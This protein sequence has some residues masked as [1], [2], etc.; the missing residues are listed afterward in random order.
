MTDKIVIGLTGNI[1]TGKSIV[2]RMLQELG[3]T[4]IDADKLVHLLMRQATP[5]YQAIVKEFGP[6]V[7][8]KNG[9]ISRAR[10][11]TIVFSDPTRLARLEAI[12]HPPVRKVILRRIEESPTPVVAIEAIKLFESG[13]SEYCQSNWVIVAKPELQLKRLVERRRMSPELA[14]QRIR[15]QGAQH[16][17]AAKADIVIDNSG[18]LVKTWSIVKQHYLKLTASL[19]A[20][21]EPVAETEASVAPATTRAAVATDISPEEITIRRAKRIDLGAMAELLSKGTAGALMPD[22]SEMMEALFSRAYMIAT[23]GDQT[24]GMIGWQTENLVAGIQD[25]YVLNDDFWSNVGLQML[26]RVHEEINDLSCE[27]ALVFVLDQA[28]RKPIEFLESQGYEVSKSEKLIP[29]WKDAAV[30]W[31]PDRSVL[32]VKKIRE[33]RIMVPM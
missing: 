20:G 29:D 9:Q 11:G 28:G 27:V 18:S 6:Q 24:L 7:L 14:K 31:Q 21:V 26:Q 15:A 33:Q 17:K 19:S 12:T 8:E 1:A 22:L 10:L 4:V 5:V 16:K 30:E 23:F 2:L 3:A 13:L 32:L 25:F